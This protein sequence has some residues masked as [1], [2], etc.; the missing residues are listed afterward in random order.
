VTSPGGGR[1]E[2]GQVIQR[3]GPKGRGRERAGGKIDEPDGYEDAVSVG[4]RRTSRSIVSDTSQ[5]GKTGG[6]P[7]LST[8]SVDEILGKKGPSR[9]SV[10]PRKKEEAAHGTGG[11][12]LERGRAETDIGDPPRRRGARR[13]KKEVRR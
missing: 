10:L 6:K 4:K 13:E 3:N 2:I 9:W 5:G 8:K 1:K 11:D 7:S 12:C